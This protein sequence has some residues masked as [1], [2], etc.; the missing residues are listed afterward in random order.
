M[1]K[2]AREGR[3]GSGLAARTNTK[4]RTAGQA[5]GCWKKTA[6][7]EAQDGCPSPYSRAAPDGICGKQLALSDFRTPAAALDCRADE[8]RHSCK[9]AKA[10]GTKRTLHLIC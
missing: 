3:S 2:S 4:G 8:T 1:P 10:R 6:G 5:R 9:C 7:K